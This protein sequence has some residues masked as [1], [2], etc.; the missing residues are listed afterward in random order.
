[1]R[2]R[3]T[4]IILLVAILIAGAFSGQKKSVGT[5]EMASDRAAN[6]ELVE[7]AIARAGLVHGSPRA[8]N[9]AVAGKRL[10]AVGFASAPV[11]SPHSLSEDATALVA[12]MCDL[13]LLADG[14][15]L[16]LSSRQ[17]SALATAVIRAQVTRQTYEAQIATSREI[18]RGQY[19]VEIPTYA[20]I[21][22]ELRQQFNEELLAELGEDAAS[23]VQQKLGGRL[24]GRFAGFGISAQTLDITVGPEG[25]SEDVQVKRTV[26]Y[27][28]SVDGRDQLATR[29]ETHFP[30]WED[31]T[32]DRWAALLSIVKA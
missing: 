18:A 22:D 11:K 1:M 19:R 26:T 10:A 7:S 15:H 16:T 12:E 28:N 14:T 27:W 23:E 25:I 29:S 17:W 13:Q 24:E 21:G 31:P 5:R 8:E 20:G 6:P 9:L 2:K 32:G 3:R 30:L 4:I